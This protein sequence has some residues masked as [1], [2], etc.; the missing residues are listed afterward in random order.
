M[1]KFKVFW[2]LL[3]F[4]FPLF[5]EEGL[6]IPALLEKYVIGKMID[7]GLKLTAEDIYSI[8]QASLKD[9]VVIFGTGCTGELISQ[10]GLV[11]TNHHCGY[12]YIQYHSSVVRDYLSNGFWAMSREEELP[13][14]DLT[15]TFL[16]RMEDVT[17]KILAGTEKVLTEQQ[18]QNVVNENIKK[19]ID[20]TELGKSYQALIKPFYYGNEYYMFIYQQFSDVRL[21]GAPP[22]SIGNF[23]E[24]FDNWMW[25]RHNGDFSLFRIYA[26]KE[27]NPASFSPDNVPYKPIKSF[28]ISLK[29][30]K[31]KD[32]TMILGYPGSTTEYLT[33]EGLKIQTDISL[34]AKIKLREM[35]MKIISDHMKRDDNI[36]I[37]Y[38]YKYRNISNSWKKWQGIVR[39]I[40]KYNA[41]SEKEKLEKRFNDWISENQERR[42]LFGGILEKLKDL[43][44]QLSVY[45]LAYEYSGENVLATEV[46]ALASDLRTFFVSNRDLPDSAKIQARN[47]FIKK[48]NKFYKDYNKSIDIEIFDFMLRSFYKDIDKGFHPGIYTVIRKRY[49]GDTGKFVRKIMSKTIL[50]SQEKIV[51]LLNE[52]PENESEIFNTIIND[53]VYQVLLSFSKTYNDVVITDYDHI[54]GQINT[55]YRSYLKGLREMEQS[56]S[57]YPDANFTMRVSYGKIEG[58]KPSDAI[59]YIHYTTIDGIHE[60][61]KIDSLYSVPSRLIQLY[62]RKDYG[63]WKNEK[64]QLPVC[65]IASN[66][67]SGGNSGSPI[68][69]GD[70]QLIG[71]NFDRNWE[72]TMSDLWYDSSICRNI[73]VDIRYILFI[74]DKFA[75]ASYLIDEMDLVW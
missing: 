60:K 49:K 72:G 56:E 13:N 51:A 6:W 32:F 58:Y 63:P 20:E 24:D 62:V 70:G 67:T 41:L 55:L 29:G 61:M 25:P 37:Q 54:Q 19:V 44:G 16:I 73:C 39:G 36:R 38:A 52:Y 43:Y 28:T 23:G 33:A 30:Y 35:R 50:S 21:V 5:A 75:G 7:D 18:Y 10:E 59:T 1:K 65:F 47:I 14:P 31:E 45:I 48:L 57:L 26:D 2:F 40:D 66:H 8:N 64:G 46:M 17:H 3:L 11:L 69:N 34:P 22:E 53:P 68:L 12:P 15:V 42:E 74:I 9:A 27:N 4:C 71:L